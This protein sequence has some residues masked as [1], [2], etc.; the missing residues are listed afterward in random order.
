MNKLKKQVQQANIR[1]HRK[2]VL[3]EK[4][5]KAIRVQKT[6]NILKQDH[7]IPKLDDSIIMYGVTRNTS[8]RIYHI[9]K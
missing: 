9:G 2:N 6:F 5:A 7:T 1:K 4:R 3:Q 8:R